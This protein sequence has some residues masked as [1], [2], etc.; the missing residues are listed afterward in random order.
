M[1]MIDFYTL[2]CTFYIEITCVNSTHGLLFWT[3]WINVLLIEIRVLFQIPPTHENLMW[4]ILV[5]QDTCRSF[6]VHVYS[7]IRFS[8]PNRTET[9]VSLSVGKFC[10]F[11]T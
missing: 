3:A 2:V 9:N 7:Y 6:V 5:P 10:F 11:K 1:F 4:L 8:I